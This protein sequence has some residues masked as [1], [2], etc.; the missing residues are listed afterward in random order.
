M[1]IKMTTVDTEDHKREKGRRGARVVKV[2]MQYY[3]QQLGDRIIATPNLSDILISHNICYQEAS[4][5]KMED[6]I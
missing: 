3:A 2:P 4:G 6:I 1:A 5:E